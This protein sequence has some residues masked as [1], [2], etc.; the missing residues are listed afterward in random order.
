MK[1]GSDVC[2]AFESAISS[3][4]SASAAFLHI[5]E[6]ARAEPKGR[7]V[8]RAIDLGLSIPLIILLSPLLLVIAVAIKWDS[9]GPIFFRQPRYGI[10]LR[11]FTIWKFRSLRHGAPDPHQRYRMLAHDERITKLGSF[12]RR[13]SLDELPQLFNVVGGSMSLVGPRPLVEWE[14][15][16]SL[17]THPERFSVKPGITGLCQ[18]RFRNWG[19][20]AARW[21]CDVEYAR[22]WSPWLDLRILL[23]TPGCVMR[24][25]KIYPRS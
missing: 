4:R 5:S 20:M 2:E 10:G 17:Q 25:E 7:F 1:T 9:S 13:T 11:P 15:L 23:Q 3:G 24:R 18:V 6:F 19:E 16:A 22:N 14:S 12:L 21:D 8:K